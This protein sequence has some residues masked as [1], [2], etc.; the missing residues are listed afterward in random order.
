[1][2]IASANPSAVSPSLSTRRRSGF[3][4]H[5]LRGVLLFGLL[6]AAWAYLAFR[7][8][9]HPVLIRG[10]GLRIYYEAWRSHRGE[11]IYR[12]FF[13]FAQ[14]GAIF[15]LHA[16]SRIF[17]FSI[18]GFHGAMAII[19][20]AFGVVLQRL[21]RSMMSFSWSCLAAAAAVL[22]APWFGMATYH[23]TAILLLCLAVLV[24]EPA[25]ADHRELSSL[26]R[27]NLA[28][29]LAGFAF[30]TMQSEGLLGAAALAAWTWKRSG[31]RRA[32]VFIFAFVLPFLCLTAY[33][34]AHH[35]LGIYLHDT[36]WFALTQTPKGT[37]QGVRGFITSW[38][39]VLQGTPDLGWIYALGVAVF[40][41]IVGPVACVVMAL[42]RNAAPR[43]RLAALLTCALI[44]SLGYAPSVHRMML[45][46]PSYVMGA[47]WL[48]RWRWSLA[49]QL[50]G[51]AL[52]IIVAVHPVARLRGQQMY[53]VDD[54]VGHGRVQTA[55][56]SFAETAAWVTQHTRPGDRIALYPWFDDELL[57]LGD[58]RKPGRIWWLDEGG[59]TSAADV[60]EVMRSLRRQPPQIAAWAPIVDYAG[61]FVPA[62]NLVPVLEY[63]HRC[64]A[65]AAVFDQAFFLR[66]IDAGAG[67]VAEGP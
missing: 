38:Q 29:L 3:D 40:T 64:Y 4:F 9:G 30:V 55:D 31:L 57:F 44:L 48:S 25:S 66:R 33:F 1:M 56:R 63:L 45:L 14:P 26:R 5:E 54:R 20:V 61:N 58:L 21:G 59:F 12:D 51:V 24:T 23:W 52:V 36:W 7:R 16:W 34:A 41:S 62:H 60:Q 27:A 28:G 10:D 17:G 18:A 42:R 22:T 35:S 2:P 49:A 67:C 43:V 32:A 47:V 8:G 6:L 11:L 15:L 46:L 65:P 19:I 13:E 53:W 37:W 39:G 50:V